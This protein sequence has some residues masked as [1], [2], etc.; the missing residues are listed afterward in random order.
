MIKENVPDHVYRENVCK[1][2]LLS[3]LRSVL[4]A[5]D[6]QESDGETIAG[7]GFLKW[8]NKVILKGGLS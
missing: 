1:D 8:L 4:L 7:M 2:T 5:R 3:V 6:S